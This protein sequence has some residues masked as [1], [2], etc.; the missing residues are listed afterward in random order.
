MVELLIFHESIIIINI[1]AEHVD[2]IITLQI[3][4]VALCHHT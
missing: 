2:L 4:F 3:C 1:R